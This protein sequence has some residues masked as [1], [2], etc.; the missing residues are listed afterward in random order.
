MKSR[1]WKYVAALTVVAALVIPGWLHAQDPE[2]HN[3]RQTH[4]T[5]QALG[6][7]GGTSCCQSET[8]NNRGW[9]DGSSNIAGDQSLHPFLWIDGRMTDLGTLGGPNSNVGGMNEVGDVTVGGSDT[10]TPDPLGEDFCSYGTHQTC[11]SFVWHNGTRTLVPTLGGNNNDVATINNRGQVLAF[12]ETATPDSTCIPPQVLGFEAFIWEPKSGDIRE[13]PPLPGDSVSAGFGMN[14]NG[15]VAGTSGICANVSSAIS[16]RP[17]H[18]TLA[19][20]QPD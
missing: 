20:R 18:R 11:L 16:K 5:V 14:E 6:S 13:L 2:N 17:P 3:K 12:A 9:V 8:I 19:K 15:D 4:Y 1:T 10:G 7:L